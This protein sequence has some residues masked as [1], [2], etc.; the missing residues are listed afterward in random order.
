MNH[1]FHARVQAIKDGLMKVRTYKDILSS[2]AT[3]L[4]AQSKDL[5]Y[6]ADLFQ[7]CTEVFKLWLEDAMRENVGSMADLSTAGLRHVI[8][9][10]D[11][12]FH[13]LQDPKVNRLH[14]RFSI[15]KDGVEGDPVE[16]YGGGAVLV[17]SLIL[18]LSVMA[19]LNM[20]NLLLLDESLS[21]L[22]NYYVP[23]AGSFLRQL[24][25]QTGVN[26]LMVTHNDDM[27]EYAHV[28]YE[29]YQ[30]E[31]GRLKLRRRTLTPAEDRTVTYRE[32]ARRDPPAA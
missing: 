10:Q 6:R 31:S 7:R 16:S 29:G 9:D 18:R 13:I 12:T 8:H 26:I 28:S 17:V 24:S 27:L 15:E 14:M 20:V 4:E 32:N 21:G 5:R 23:S 25:E 1:N 30:D 22:A 11:L 2:Q 3:D 19:R